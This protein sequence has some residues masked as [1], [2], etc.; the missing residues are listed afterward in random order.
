M[1]NQYFLFKLFK[2]LKKSPI[3]LKISKKKLCAEFII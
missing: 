1:F 3:I 2:N